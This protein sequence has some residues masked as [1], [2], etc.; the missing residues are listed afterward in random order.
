M[1]ISYN[2][3]KE[4]VDFSYNIEDLDKTLTMLGIEVEEVIDYKKKYEN[5]VTAEVL[6]AEKHPKADKL[7]ICD[8]DYGTGIAK[9]I[10]GAP[11]VAQGQKVIIGLP[12]AKVPSTGFIIEKRK[13]RDV[14]SNGMICSEA[15][16][17][18]GEDSSGIKVLYGDT[19][20][21]I[22]LAEYLNMDDIILDVSLTPNKA[23]C[24]SHLGIARELAAVLGNEVVLPNNNVEESNKP[25]SDSVEVIIED[26]EKCLRYSARIIRGITVTESPEWLK[27]RLILIGL[28]PVNVVVDVTNYV[29]M[30]QGQPLHAFDL[31]KIDGN[32]IICKTAKNAEKFTTLDG[33]ER[34]LDD[35]MLMICDANK[36]IAIG[37]VMG[38][39]NS[40]INNKTID[41][42]L[43]SAFFA[44]SSIRKTS[45]KLGIQ[46][47][48]SY[49]FERGVDIDNV[50]NT[51]NRAAGLIAELAGG[52]IDKGYID[53]YPAPVDKLIVQFRYQRANDIIGINIS[54]GQMKDM[55][56][57]MRFNI[58]SEDKNSCTVEVPSSR[59]DVSLEIDL[60][61]EI[62]RLFNYD[63]IQPD[64]SISVSLAGENIHKDLAIPP[65]RNGISDYLVKKGFNEIITQNMLDPET[66]ALFGE[67]PVK[68]SNPLGEDLSIM[69][70]SL[71]PS[72][73]RTIE[74][75]IR[76][77][78]SDLKL[79]EIG[80]SFHKVDDIAKTFIK[81]IFEQEELIVALTGRSTPL[82]WGV[83]ERRTDFYDIKGIYEELI[84]FFK[85]D[86]IKF[87]KY[88]SDFL[89]FGKNSIVIKHGNDVIGSF[90]EV[91][92]E[93][94]KYFDIENPVYILILDLS[95][96]YGFEH[97]IPKYSSITAYPAITRDLAFIMSSNIENGTVQNEILGNGGELLKSLVLFDVYD[98]KSIEKGMKS[99]AYSLTFS[100]PERTL[101]DEEVEMHLSKII[102][103]VEKRFDA[104][105]RKQ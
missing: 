44:P 22:P 13:I 52:T 68:I 1:Y 35:S 56:R 96:V 54:P 90:G 14:E 10:C 40:E 5:F 8:V 104:N 41:V 93:N 103:A 57:R 17:Q 60:I 84:E 82:Q 49:R 102:R 67:P 50:I 32:K 86:N 66:A 9:V 7:T 65:L 31:S 91:S 97:R 79:F 76:L 48:A 42:L 25:V 101:K 88:D 61:E 59:V 58:I 46:S 55:L 75:N 11:N 2:W 62:A 30:E 29:L 99:M 85:F 3:L 95:K 43:E 26:K 74:R 72:M 20:T 70:T 81:N 94:L 64:Y 18:I 38:G 78:N 15:E 36:N 89:V 45:K 69:R 51:L 73:L 27:Q 47:D 34:I 98:G 77:G 105:L 83:S 37:G 33:T 4:L 16:L 71:V 53:T 80:K 23:D 92:K 19:K 87:E 100:S 39:R 12:G 24:N 21:G 28:R 6:S 63:N